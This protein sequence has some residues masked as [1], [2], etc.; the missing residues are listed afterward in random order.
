[1]RS[2]SEG[3]PYRGI[4]AT[5]CRRAAPVYPRLMS[6]MPERH[7][8]F[9]VEPMRCW[10]L[11]YNRQLQATSLRRRAFVDGSL[12][13]PHWRALVASVGVSGPSGRLNRSPGVRAATGLI[14]FA[15]PTW[16][17]PRPAPWSYPPPGFP[18]VLRI[19]SGRSRQSYAVFSWTAGEIDH[20][21]C[22]VSCASETVRETCQPAFFREPLQWAS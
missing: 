12:V 5:Y 10:A 22:A 4:G 2:G 1:M 18:A 7:P 17:R 13:S 3:A 20:R 19:S 15:L 16:R 21:P 8:G 9:I 11:V 14:S 6:P